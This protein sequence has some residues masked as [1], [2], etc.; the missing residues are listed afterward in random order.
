MPV[1]LRSPTPAP[2]LPDPYLS[3]GEVA[4]RLGMS[5]RHV[6]RLC[7]E[8]WSAR[9]LARRFDGAWGVHP[10]ADPRLSDL[11]TSWRD[12]D[13][14][15]FA[16]LRAAG[17]R[18]HYLAMAEARRD[19]LMAFAAFDPPRGASA[20]EA[21]RAFLAAQRVAGRIGA[22]AA[23]RSASV[24]TLYRWRA[25]YGCR[26]S[27]GIQALLPGYGD[28]DGDDP[29][30]PAAWQHALNLLNCGDR[31]SAAVAYTLTIGHRDRLGL[32]NDPAWRMPA[33]RTFQAIAR[34]RRPKALR[35]ACDKGLRAMDAACIP[36]GARDYSQVAAGECY[37]G[38]ERTLDILVR[39][40]DKRGGWAVTRCVKLTAWMD[41]RSR[42]IVGWVIAPFA[43]TDTILV[44]LVRAIRAHGIPERVRTDQGKDYRAAA[45]GIGSRPRWDVDEFDA[46]RF[47][48]AIDRLGIE[49][50]PATAYMPWA[51][52]IESFFGT[53]AERFDVL[54]RGYVTGATATRHEDRHAWAKRNVTMLP[55]LAEV[56]AYFEAWVSIYNATPHTGD[57]MDGLAPADAMAQFRAG[58]IRAAADDLIEQCVLR[59][60]PADKPLL[61]HRDG[62][63]YLKSWYGWGDSR[64]IEMQGQRVRLGIHP[65]DAGHAW[66]CALDGSLLFRVESERHRFR[67]RQDA[68]QIARQRGGMRREMGAIARAAR[69]WKLDIDPAELL[70]DQ[71]AG[72]AAQRVSA[73]LPET[74]PAPD[75]GPPRLTLAA[76]DI[77]ATLAAERA[78]ESRFEPPSNGDRDTVTLEDMLDPLAADAGEVDPP[79][80]EESDGGVTIDDMIGDPGALDD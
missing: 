35:V 80:P 34:A 53:M 64:V 78:R 23:I 61:V 39:L 20:I 26:D 52:S 2:Q 40:P 1:A 31:I 55:T 68:Q 41:E 43:N 38:D 22:S 70:A 45:R 65:D 11:R 3:V 48:A 46:T 27:G 30:G 66:V 62:I 4:A 25:A 58:P 10:S 29:I 8:E 5:D 6:R 67:T 49:I 76:P 75:G 79:D 60:T 69:D 63:R 54:H 59:L 57:A 72:V 24:G 56:V 74:P 71:A 42:M 21:A 36:K 14:A 17:T 47:G 16:A 19:L 7:D 18:P 50:T 13:L 51:K 9:Q 32:R 28:G 37:V 44:S 77:S 15:Q 73:G 12:R 33:L